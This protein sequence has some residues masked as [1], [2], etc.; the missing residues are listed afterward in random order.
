MCRLAAYLGPPVPLARLTHEPPHSLL[1]QSWKPREMLEAVLNAD[2]VGAAWF[3]DDGN[4][5]PCRYR[6]PL[7]AW[8]DENLAQLAPRVRSSRLL[9]IV[10]AA[11]PGLQVAASST[12]PFV[13]G[14]LAFAHNG[15]LSRFH[16]AFMRPLRERLSDAA[17][18]S[19]TGGTDSE[20]L[21][22]LLVDD[23]AGRDDA[24]SVADALVRLV[25]SVD[26]LAK[27]VEAR[28]TMNLVVA[29]P[30]GLVAVRYASDGDA[31]S[32]YLAE[33]ARRFDPGIVLASEPLDDDPA[34]KP[35]AARSVVRVGEDARVRIEPLP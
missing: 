7:A 16:A 35:V 19:I 25:L 1:V 23:L 10:R 20:H 21:F 26:R 27:Q 29:G 28:A 9:A 5:A 3:P 12:P 4:P 11:T 17:Y 15:A 13:H 34:W 8:Q 6:A 18:A 22:A 14:H 33:G 30:G 31:P 24:D 2:G 32:L